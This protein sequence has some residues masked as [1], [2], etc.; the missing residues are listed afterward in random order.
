MAHCFIRQHKARFLII[1]LLV[2]HAIQPDGPV[3]Q[4]RHAGIPD[5]NARPRAALVWADDVETQKAVIWAVSHDSDGGDGL[6]IAPAIRK[7]SGSAV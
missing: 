7:P 1:R 4:M 6:S 2:R 5:G 3:T